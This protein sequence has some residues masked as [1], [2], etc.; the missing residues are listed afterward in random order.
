MNQSESQAFNQAVALYQAGKR[1]EAKQI[2]DNLHLSHPNDV[3]ILLWQIYTAD[4]PDDARNALNTATRLNPDHPG[5]FQARTWLDSQAQPQQVVA[6]TV[7]PVSSSRNR[8][9]PIVIVLSLLVVGGIITFAL[10]WTPTVERPAAEKV[11]NDFMRTAATS[12]LDATYALS[13]PY[14]AKDD[15]KTGLLDKSTAYLPNYDHLQVLDFSER[16]GTDNGD[17]FRY[18]V[19]SGTAFYKNN[20]GKGSFIAELE[21]YDND[22]KVVTIDLTPPAP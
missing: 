13:S 7:K 12:N 11:L 3:N 6:S 21:K 22:W 8:I 14:L 5:L 1:A 18:L 9:W 20:L 10:V 15:V 4:N 19:F 2:L 17:D 16:N